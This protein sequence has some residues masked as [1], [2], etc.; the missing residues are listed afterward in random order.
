MNNQLKTWKAGFLPDTTQLSHTMHNTQLT[1]NDHKPSGAKFPLSIIANDITDPLN[2]GSLFRLCDA[3]GIKKLYL[4]GNTPIPPHTKINKTSRSTEKYVDYEYQENV[5]ELIKQL[6]TNNALIASLELTTESIEV[7]DVNFQKAVT[8]AN[9]VYLIPG[10]ENNGVNETL[11]SLSDACI[12]I[13][14]HGNNSSMNVISATSIACF[15]IC[16]NLTLIK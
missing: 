1:H 5:Q 8:I 11:L 7:D 13:P 12:H 14:M 4:C 16:K 9:D 6:K 15:E 10:S 2:V 3:L